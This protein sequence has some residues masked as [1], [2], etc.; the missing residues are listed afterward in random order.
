MLFLF[1]VQL[2]PDT[3]HTPARL[4]PLYC[5]PDYMTPTAC[6][7]ILS[8]PYIKSPRSSLD[9]CLRHCLLDLSS[10]LSSCLL[11]IKTCVVKDPSASSIYCTAE[12]SGC[13]TWEGGAWGHGGARVMTFVID[14]PTL[15]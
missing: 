9:S 15:R 11:I 12:V 6:H 13:R 8:R 5:R 1:C 10:V 3:N 2:N 14:P 4:P 7:C